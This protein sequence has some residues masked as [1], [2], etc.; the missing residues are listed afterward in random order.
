MAMTSIRVV[1]V[2]GRSSPRKSL[3][4][5]LQ[6]SD[7]LRQ[8]EEQTL[9]IE[10]QLAVLKK[11]VE[12][13]IGPKGS[14]GHGLRLRRLEVTRLALF[15]HVDAADRFL[16]A[17]VLARLRNDL[18]AISDPDERTDTLT[19]AVLHR[20]VLTGAPVNLERVVDALSLYYEIKLQLD[21]SGSH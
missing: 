21:R 5:A 1:L 9:R 10:A 20:K 18:A 14:P 17:P 16:G 3:F 2:L 13:T 15:A 19:A 11:D 4:G 7:R 8:F 12:N 6:T